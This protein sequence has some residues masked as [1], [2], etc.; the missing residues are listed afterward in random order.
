MAGSKDKKGIASAILERMSPK[1]EAG[2]MDVPAADEP[3]DGLHSA[4]E[5]VIS[6]VEA[7]DPKAL[8]SALKSF[9]EMC[10]SE[11]DSSEVV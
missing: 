3:M 1:P 9:I 7:K 8:V 5:E 4:A 11:G 6:A 2:P 10:G